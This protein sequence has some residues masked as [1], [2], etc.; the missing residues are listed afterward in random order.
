VKRIEVRVAEGGRVRRTRKDEG[1]EGGWLFPNKGDTRGNAEGPYKQKNPVGK[2]PTSSANC[3]HWEWRKKGFE[4]PLH[5]VTVDSVLSY[6][7]MPTC[8]GVENSPR[9]TFGTPT[10]EKVS[11]SS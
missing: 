6:S 8:L 9:V 10:G 4:R 11:I 2:M 5:W 1:G 3:V 7:G